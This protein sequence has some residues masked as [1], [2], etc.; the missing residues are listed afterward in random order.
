MN[1]QPF[2]HQL[3][4]SSGGYSDIFSVSFSQLSNTG[5]HFGTESILK[6]GTDVSTKK[7]ELS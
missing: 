1:D 4:S 6:L 2:Q 3:F 7:Q 5:K